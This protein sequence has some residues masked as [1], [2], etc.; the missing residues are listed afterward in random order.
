MAE[1]PQPLPRTLWF[2]MALVFLLL[3]L[4][5]LLSFAEMGDTRKSPLPVLNQVADFALT[6][7]ADQLTTLDDL[8]NHY[9]IVRLIHYIELDH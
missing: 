9:L 7:Q 4:A 6:N 2:G 3:G 5:Y 8:T 1:T